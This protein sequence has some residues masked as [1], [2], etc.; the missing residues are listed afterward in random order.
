MPSM[1]VVSSDID[2]LGESNV[3]VTV[4]PGTR[5]KVKRGREENEAKVKKKKINTRKKEIG[6]WMER[7]WG[8]LGFILYLIFKEKSLQ[9]HEHG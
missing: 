2:D 9:R 1:D 8:Y 4:S 3:S 5:F 7:L 6:W